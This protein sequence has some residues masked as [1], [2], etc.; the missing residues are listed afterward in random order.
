MKKG[1]SFGHR[2]HPAGPHPHSREKVPPQAQMAN[3][4]HHPVS[5]ALKEHKMDS[6]HSES[7]E[8]AQGEY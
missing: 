7:I 1:I 5:K 8:N 4:M 3:Q 6:M 2:G